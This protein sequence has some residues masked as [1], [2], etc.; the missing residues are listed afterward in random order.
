ML[1]HIPPGLTTAPAG[2]KGHGFGFP[3]TATHRH[4][5]GENPHG[6]RRRADGRRKQV[7]VIARCE[8]PPGTRPWSLT[9]RW[10]GASRAVVG[11]RW[12]G[13]NRGEVASSAVAARTVPPGPL[14]HE[15]GGVCGP[16]RPPAYP[17]LPRAAAMIGALSAGAEIS[18]P[19]GR[20][21]D[22][23][24]APR[25][26]LPTADMSQHTPWAAT[27]HVWT[28]P[29]WQGISSRA[30]VW[31]EQPCVRPV[32]AAHVTAGHNA[33]RGSGP[34]HEHAFDNALARV[35]CPDRQIDRGSALRAVCPFQPSHHAGCPGAICF[36]PRVRRVLCSARPWPSL[37]RPSE[38]TCWLRPSISRGAWVT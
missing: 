27:G 32:N 17:S 4:R 24:Q 37:P 26:L 28:A 21:L 19:P 2:R 11:C 7:C 9:S 35:G 20:S 18:L 36:T 34:G 29:G 10:P 13:S 5:A 23:L 14:A 3:S 38:Q 8:T 22:K 16:A 6:V 25:Q 1:G 33:F 12:P 30:Q 31:S 15:G